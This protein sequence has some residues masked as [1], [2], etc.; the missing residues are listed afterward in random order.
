MYLTLKEAA[1]TVDVLNGILYTEGT[2]KQQHI[3][4][5]V[6]DALIMDS[7][8]TKW[9]LDASERD[10]FVVKLERLTED[11]AGELLAKVHAYWEVGTHTDMQQGLRDAGL[12]RTPLPFEGELGG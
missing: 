11:E 3:Y 2:S 9:D 6:L 5:N 1:A 8:G 12:V 7:L 4:H 10:D